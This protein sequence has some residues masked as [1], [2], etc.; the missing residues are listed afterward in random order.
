MKLISKIDVRG[1]DEVR[2]IGLYHGDLTKQSP[3]HAVDILIVSAFPDDYTP[4]HGSLIGALDQ[5]GLS[6]SALSMNKAF[7][8]RSTSGFWLSQPLRGQNGSL[9]IGRVLCFEP[10]IIGTPPDTV[11]ELFR[12]LFPFLKDDHDAIIAMPLVAVGDQ[13]WPPSAIV[14]PLLEAAVKWFGRGLPVRELKIVERSLERLEPLKREFDCFADKFLGFVGDSPIDL[15]DDKKDYDVFVS[16]SSR[17]QVAADKFG[18]ALR[19]QRPE[20]KIFDFRNSIAKGVSYQQVI[21]K[22]IESCRRIVAIL[23]PDYFESPE[24][25]E[26]IMMSRLRNK[27]ADGGVLLP[28]YWRDL[29]GDLSLW[30]QILNYSDCREADEARIAAAACHEAGQL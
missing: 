23:S 25:V 22:A 27:R 3:E 4:T 26:E 18:H 2:R 16:Y 7:D 21:D 10:S 24:C 28:I 8:L 5:G 13:G 9:N 6:I 19:V 12:G 11:G 1:G 30:L 15:S 17:D 14:P 20:I 29:G